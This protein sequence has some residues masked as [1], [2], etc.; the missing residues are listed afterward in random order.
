MP[1]SSQVK[2]EML[3]PLQLDFLDGERRRNRGDERFECTP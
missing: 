2:S 3:S 1:A